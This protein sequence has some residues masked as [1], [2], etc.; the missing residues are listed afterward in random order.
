MPSTLSLLKKLKSAHPKFSF[1]EGADFRWDFAAQTITYPSPPDD[2]AWQAHLLHELAHAELGHQKYDRDIE[3]IAKERDAW[4]HT[5]AVLSPLYG[6]GIE[7]ETIESA[8]DS[9]RDWLHARST[10]PHCQAT[11]LEIKKSTYQCPACRHQ[12]RV[13]EARICHLR[14][15]EIQK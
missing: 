3:L 5:R 8:M 9:Y 10:C 4:S 6:V 1:H 2:M 11:G 12:W 14:R 15:Y 13:N 7:L